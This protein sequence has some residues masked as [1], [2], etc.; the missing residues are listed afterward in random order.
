[1]TVQRGGTALPVV[2]KTLVDFTSYANLYQPCAS[3]AASVSG[4]PYAA[5]FAAGFASTALPIAPNAA[6]HSGLPVC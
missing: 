3:L 5:A 4:S 1:V 6:R 2:G